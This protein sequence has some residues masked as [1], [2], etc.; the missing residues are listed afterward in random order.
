[1]DPERLKLVALILAFLLMALIP[2]KLEIVQKALINGLMMLQDYA[3]HHTLFCLL[4]A[5]FIAGGIAVFIR[6]DTVIRYL[7][8][9]VKRYISYSIAAIAGGILAVCSCTILPLFAGIYKRGSGLGPALTFLYAGPAINI[10]AIFLTGR[11]LGW[12]ISIIRL[13]FSIIIAVIVGM[14]MGSLF[15]EKSEDSSGFIEMDEEFSLSKLSI[16]GLFLP[17]AGILVVNSIKMA[18]V[19]KY[20]FIGTAVLFLLVFDKMHINKEHTNNWLWRTW[21]FIK[22]IFPYLFIGIF[23]AGIIGVLLPEE[24]VQRLIG[25]NRLSSTFFASIFGSLMYF[26]TL[27]EVP[28]IAQ[29]MKLGM[30]KGPALSLF[31]AGYSL[32]LPNMIAIISLIGKKR[33]LVFYGLVVLF[34]A[35][36]GYIYGNYIHL[37]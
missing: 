30:G 11:V 21:F 32:S 31:L 24:V 27:T 17:L 33:A 5:F 16:A 14:I 12:E 36:A 26:A 13:V 9:K 35:F 4:P 1:M 34:S 28:I 2:F 3:Q 29:L 20:A 19:L 37:F 22:K 7:G 10:A 15:K 18:P 8:A 23:I 6:K 25:G